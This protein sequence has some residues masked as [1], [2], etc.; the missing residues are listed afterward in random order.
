MT[1]TAAN[2]CNIRLVELTDA[3]NAEKK[4]P[5]EW[6]NARGNGVTSEFVDYVEG[7]SSRAR[8]SLVYENGMPRFAKLKKDRRQVI[9]AARTARGARRRGPPAGNPR[10]RPLFCPGAAGKPAPRTARAASLPGRPRPASGSRAPR[11][12]AANRGW[13]RGRRQVVTNP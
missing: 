10:R 9:R 1:A 13:G 7:R 2:Q 12:P 4:V 8:P 6:I 5:L 3:A 11:R